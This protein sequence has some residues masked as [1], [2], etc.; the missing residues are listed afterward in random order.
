MNGLLIDLLGAMLIL[1]GAGSAEELTEYESERFEYYAQHPLR[2]NQVPRSRLLS[3]GLLSSYQVAAL[4][5]YRKRNGDILGKTELSLVDGIGPAAAEA[6]A[7]FVS[8][9][10]ALPPGAK[11]NRRVRQ[12]LTARSFTRIRDSD[13]SFAMGGKYHI[14]FGDRAEFFWSSRTSYSSPDF[15][16]GTFSLALYSRRGA[17]LI[18]GDYAARFGQGLALWSSMSISGFGSVSAFRRSGSGFAPTGSF[19][20]V[21]R[22]VAADIPIGRW[23]LGGAISEGGMPTAFVSRLGHRGRFGIQ[24]FRKDGTVV[25]ADGDIALGHWTLFGESAVSSQLVTSDGYVLRRTRLAALGGISWAPAYKLCM[26]A[27]ARYYPKDFY[28]PYAG[29]ARSASK[30]SDET[31]FSLGAQWRWAEFTADAASHPDKGTSQYRGIVSLTPEFKAG[32]AVL[33]PCLRWTG[34]CRPGDRQPW[35][36]ELRCDIKASGGAFSGCVRIDLV[37]SKDWGSLCYAEAAYSSD[38]ERLRCMFLLRG[39]SYRADAWADRIYCYERDLPG[40]FSVP[41]RYGRG[42]VLSAMSSLRI[43][44]SSKSFRSHGLYLKTSMLGKSS[45]EVKLQYQLEV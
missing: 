41:A 5:D 44:P 32:S 45:F 37:R 33:N 28:A 2:L 11:E 34:K 17:R 14:E 4:E 10:S 18:L 42:W 23:S 3:S 12:S 40:C 20:P 24:A 22:G 29:A 9:D 39:T 1:S 21:F 15:R 43:R 31:G 25:S 16:P 26:T 38:G 35:R 7:F 8:F 13:T 6:L 19:S 30:V 27:L 36:N